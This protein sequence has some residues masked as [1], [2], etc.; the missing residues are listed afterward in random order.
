MSEESQSPLFEVDDAQP[1]SSRCPMC[2]ATVEVG[3]RKCVACGEE[4][5]PTANELTIPLFSLTAIGV[6]TFFWSLI[7]GMIL[8]W[9]NCRRLEKY[10]EALRT[11]L[12]GV[13]MFVGLVIVISV[14]PEFPG[15]NLAVG[16]G[17]TVMVTQYAKSVL[18]EPLERQRQQG[19]PY[20][21]IWLAHGIGLLV[22]LGIVA[23]VISLLVLL[24]ML[25]VEVEM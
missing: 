5:Q 9:M 14:L 15:A 1:S 6:G 4:L 20:R 3:A 25:G 13:A 21:S 12:L 18:G 11:I 16:I 2:G 22:V 19:G 24:G 17:C 7:T 10:D 8:V 23:A